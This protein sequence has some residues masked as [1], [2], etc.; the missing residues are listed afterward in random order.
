MPKFVRLR[1]WWLLPAALDFFLA[2]LNHGWVCLFFIGLGVWMLW[3]L[4][5]HQDVYAQKERA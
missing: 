1:T 5:K 3:P 4:K 2:G